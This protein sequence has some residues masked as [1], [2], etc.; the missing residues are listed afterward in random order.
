MY[1]IIIESNAENFLKKLD[2]KEAELILKKIY[3]IRKN[4]FR[5]LKKL[6]GHKLWRLRITN[7]R[8]II[9]VV[10][11]NKKIIILRIGFKKNIY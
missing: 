5:F 7:Y 8:A 4:P 10:V 6:Q 9:S 2:K 1:D 11:S 3:S